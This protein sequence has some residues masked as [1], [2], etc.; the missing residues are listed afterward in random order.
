MISHNFTHDQ[1]DMCPF[2]SASDGEV[3]SQAPNVR[4]AYHRRLKPI[5]CAEGK[6]KNRYFYMVMAAQT[7]PISGCLLSHGLPAGRTTGAPVR[8]SGTMAVSPRIWKCSTA[9]FSAAGGTKAHD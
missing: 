9:H 8:L 3:S 5:T 4:A 1:T 6:A 2:D 7:M